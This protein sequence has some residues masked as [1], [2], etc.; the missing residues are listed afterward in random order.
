MLSALL[1]F[2]GGSAFRMIWG[3][4]STWLTKRQDH[5]H[6]MEMMRL[7]ADLDAQRHALQ[8]DAIRLQAE[9]GIKVIEA[10]REA[11]VDELETNAWL[12]AV[13]ATGRPV[14][15]AWVDAWNAAIRPAGA[16]WALA[17]LTL[18][19]L[20]DAVTVSPTVEAVCFA[21]LG[22]FVADR[23]MGKRGK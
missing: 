6:E 14:G 19:L 17:V 8:M 18:D 11:V 1:S 13:K 21:F 7:Q 3:E 9:Q 4:V 12:E 10:Q 5:A 22:L 20:F 2:L 15:V 23:A 16:T